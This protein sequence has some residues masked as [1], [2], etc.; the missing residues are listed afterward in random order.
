MSN[1]N[2]VL[3]NLEETGCAYGVATK[4]VQEE[5]DS[6]TEKRISNMER[7][8]GRKLDKID[9]KIMGADKAITGLSTKIDDKISKI[10][11]SAIPSL[12]T[13]L[14]IVLTIIILV[15]QVRK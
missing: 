12:L 10:W 5:R 2:K 15:L 8:I 4:A 14:G 3:K 13:F 9:L 6:N 11:M 1:G 7:W